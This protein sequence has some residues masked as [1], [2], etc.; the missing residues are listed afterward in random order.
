M[1]R[2]A[3]KKTRVPHSKPKG[4][5]PENMLSEKIAEGLTFGKD[6]LEEANEKF[7]TLPGAVDLTYM[8]KEGGIKFRA[9]NARREQGEPEV[10]MRMPDGRVMREVDVAFSPEDRLKIEQGYVC[11]RCL[12]PQ[13]AM[14]ADD[15][16]EGCMGVAMYGERYMRDGYHTIDVAAEFDERMVHVGPGRPLRAAVEA[17]DDRNARLAWIK[18]QVDKGNSD[19]AEKE[20]HRVYASEN[21]A[22][23]ADKTPAR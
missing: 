22:R 1:S 18:Q 23:P 11:I 6:S 12:E 13:S 14:N 7:P 10:I 17:Q 3:S 4:I 16:I 21:Q 15:H 5:D 2:K 9:L 8:L 19:S 20:L